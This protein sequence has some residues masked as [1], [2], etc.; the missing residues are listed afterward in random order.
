MRCIFTRDLRSDTSSTGR[1]PV[2]PLTWLR[3]AGFAFALRDSA[4]LAFSAS[5][6]EDLATS[7]G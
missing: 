5:A 2:L 3:S 7:D 4:W 6:D 1:R